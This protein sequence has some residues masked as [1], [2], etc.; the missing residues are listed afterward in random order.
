MSVDIAIEEHVPL[1][2]LTTLGIGGAA[3]YFTRARDAKDIR[4][5]IRWAATHDIPLL[6]LGGGSNLLVSDAGFPGLVVKMELGGIQVEYSDRGAR[7]RVGAGETWDSIVAY[8]VERDLAGIECLSGIP[9]SV[10][11]TPIQNVGA[12]G[13]EVRETITAV[14]VLDRSDMKVKTLTNS[15]C[16]FAYRQ[17]RFKGE[18]RDRFIVLAVTFDLKRG[19][20]PSVRYPELARALEAAGRARPSIRD[21]RDVVISIRRKKG[22]V[23]DPADPDSR[24]A[25]SFF[26][27]PVVGADVAE[28]VRKRAEAR[29]AI[30]ESAQMP[31]FPT[32]ENGRIKL[33]AA[34]LIE[35]SGFT[36]GYGEGRAGLSTKHTLAV[37][38]RGGARAADVVALVDEIRGKVREVFGITIEPEPNFVGFD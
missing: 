27:N 34:W 28:D 23:I 6:I 16:H 36:R 37:V 25:G 12:Y 18:D 2:P 8:A 30:T 19:G 7:V 33:S 31:A 21:V 1:A 13:Q 14:E 17:S 3:R 9:G 22:M 32:E 4:Y 10:G 38:N 26:M 35:H 29:G 5:A 11:A 24:S 15:D 20:P